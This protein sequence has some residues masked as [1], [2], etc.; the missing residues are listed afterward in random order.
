MNDQTAST[1]S[2]V[3]FYCISQIETTLKAKDLGNA[4][5]LL[6]DAWQLVTPGAP[7]SGP[8]PE[9]LTPKLIPIDTQ[10]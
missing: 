5:R 7:E 3:S 9:R 10:R 6:Q 1:A 4:E 8:F 2:G